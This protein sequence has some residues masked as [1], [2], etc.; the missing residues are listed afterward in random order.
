MLLPKVLLSPAYL[1]RFESKIDQKDKL[2]KPYPKFLSSE[3]TALLPYLYGEIIRSDFVEGQKKEVF[4]PR[5]EQIICESK[6]S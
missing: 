4:Y 3:N 1:F 6:Q 5:I 2:L